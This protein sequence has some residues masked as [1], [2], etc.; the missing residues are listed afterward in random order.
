LLRSL[1]SIKHPDEAKD[2]EHPTFDLK[3]DVR[4]RGVFDERFLHRLDDSIESG[5]KSEVVHCRVNKDGNIGNINQSD[6]ADADAFRALLRY[7]E[8]LIGR[9][10]D[11]LIDGVVDV[12][13]YRMG[14]VT[15]CPRCEFRSVCRFDPAINNY[16]HLDSMK[17]TTV[18]NVLR[19][20]QGGTR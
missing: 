17:R 11:E 4:P 18:L 8:R 1:E 6:A 2:P 14:Q 3:K 7:V 9:M 19:E 13:P 12:E 20:G 5:G 10:A 15:P 16:Y